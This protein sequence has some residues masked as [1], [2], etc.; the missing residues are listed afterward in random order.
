MTIDIEIKLSLDVDIH[1]RKKKIYQMLI[2]ENKIKIE[3]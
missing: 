3:Y 2:F 1:N